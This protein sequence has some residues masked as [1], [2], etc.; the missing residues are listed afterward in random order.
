MIKKICLLVFVFGVMGLFS[1]TVLIGSG[2]TVAAAPEATGTIQGRVRAED[3]G[4][5]GDVSVRASASPGSYTTTTDAAGFYTFTVPVHP[6]GYELYFSPV[7]GASFLM[8]KPWP[9]RINILDKE[10][11]AGIDITLPVGGILTG[12]LFHGATQLPMTGS[13]IQFSTPNRAIYI[14][15]N[16]R[17]GVLNPELVP[18]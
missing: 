14:Y 2:H 11:R 7:A 5:V 13:G 10:V 15:L 1:L 6:D 17:R 3:G 9:G 12:N 18:A 16:A 8:A 4:E